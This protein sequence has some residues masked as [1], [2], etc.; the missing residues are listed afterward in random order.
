MKRNVLFMAVCC[1]CGSSFANPV[2]SDSTVYEITDIYSVSPTLID[3]AYMGGGWNTNWF[4]SVQGGGSLFKGSPVGC[5]DMYDRMK[6]TINISLGK[7]VSPFVGIRLDYEGMKLKDGNLMTSK[8]Q[9]YHAD[10]MYNISSHFRRDIAAFSKWDIIPFVG[11]GLLRNCENK[12]RPFA[13]SYGLMARLHIANRLYLNG[14]ISGTTTFSDFDGIGKRDA[15]GDNLFHA[16]VGLTLAVGKV[17]WQ[18]VIDAKPYMYLSDRLQV[19]LQKQKELNEYHAK[20]LA[21]S[22]MAVDEMKKI[23]AVEGLLERYNINMD[24]EEKKGLYPK[25]NYSGLNSLR[26]RLK[27][28]QGGND[29]LSSWNDSCQWDST[30]STDKY[31]KLMADGKTYIGA[32]IFFFFKIKTSDF[33]DRSQEINA[34]EIAKVMKKY[35]LSAKIVG[36]ADSYTGSAGLNDA[37]SEQRAK[38]IAQLLK[39]YKVSDK[40]ISIRHRGGI[41]DY[42]PAEGNR[43]TCVLLYIK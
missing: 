32:P 5:G 35:N 43:N 34:R 12:N 15:F 7:W 38:Y 17:G 9:N 21:E 1:I 25:N 33:T 28:R 4:L 27:N 14:E 6:P 42:D 13:F 24:A 37:L 26:A 16:T 3:G 36:A 31:L 22:K 8:Y 19:T 10:I 2:C 23:L 41:D 29:Q 39:K 40:N 11:T 30:L 18:H 20:Q